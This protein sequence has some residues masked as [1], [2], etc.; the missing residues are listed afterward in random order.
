MNVAFYGAVGF[1]LLLLF[2]CGGGRGTSDCR[3][4]LTYVT[5]QYTSGEDA[6][7]HASEYRVGLSMG[8]DNFVVSAI[9]DTASPQL[10]INEKNYAFGALTATGAKPF[11]HR[12]D[13]QTATA[14]NAKDNV[15]VGCMVDKSA[16]FMITAKEAS[17]DNVLGVSFT[18]HGT[19]NDGRPFFDQLVT[20]EGLHDIF[21]LALC[22]YIGNS[23]ILFGGIDNAMKPYIGNFV[24]IIERSDYVV[25]AVTLRLGDNKRMLAEFPSYN[26]IT[27]EGVR[28]IIDS[29]SAFLLLPVA[30]ANTVA[31]EVSNAANSL[32]LLNQFPAGFFRTERGNSTKVIRFASL[33][34]I[35]QFPSLEIGLRGTDGT[36]KNLEIPPQH[37]FKEVD[38][39]D[40]LVRTFAIRESNGDAVLGQPFL[41]SHYAVFDRK[42]GVIGFGNIDMACSQ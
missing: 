14:I 18:D 17:I 8:A 31:L 39:E 22:R 16:R 26:A 2:N 7:R 21:S 19:S 10:V 25:P 37:Y 42:N 34:Q 20:D 6:I 28:T 29:A 3:T 35:R 1:A 24:P 27:K 9:L 30:M 11:V 4:P 36:I 13:S 23:R 5:N 12:S 38:S 33:A 41:E 40:A 15:D 32:N